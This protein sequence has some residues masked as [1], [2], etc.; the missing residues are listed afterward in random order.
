MRGWK[1]DIDGVGIDTP[2]R[3]ILHRE[4]ILKKRFL[5]KI[6]CEWYNHLRVY[7]G[8]T[9]SKKILEIG[10]G[11]GFIKEIMPYVLTS[12]IIK[13]PTCDTV[14]DCTNIPFE[15]NY[16]DSILMVDVL[17]HISNI[18]L[19]FLQAQ[20]KLKPGGLIV[21]SEP[22]NCSWSRFIYKNFHHEPFDVNADWNIPEKGPLSGANGALPWI[23]F[24]RD[25]DMFHTKFPKLKLKKIEYHTPTRY[26][27]SGGVSYKQFVPDFLFPAL[28]AFDNFFASKHFNMFAFITVEKVA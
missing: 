1:E 18:D 6:Y 10:S 14:I 4:I 28:S 19:F 15:D 17:H 26:L 5:K 24:E 2:E 11:A 23:V 22:W 12:D 3:T 7:C 9:D 20:A 8:Y 25:I 13:L 27:L 16:F 21:M